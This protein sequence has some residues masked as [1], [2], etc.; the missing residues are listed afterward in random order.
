MAIAVPE[1]ESQETLEPIYTLDFDVIEAQGRDPE[2]LVASRRCN[3]CKAAPA[4]DT[5]AKSQ[6]ASIKDHRKRI[7]T[8]CVKEPVL[9]GGR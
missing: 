7:Q 6:K 2:V 8:Q 4:K 1:T 9:W 3:A 5:K